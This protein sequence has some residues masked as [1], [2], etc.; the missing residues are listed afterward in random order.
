MLDTLLTLLIFQTMGEGLVYVFSLPIPGP[1]IGMLLLLCYLIIRKG[2]ADKLA[3]TT[4]QLLSHMALLFVPAGVGISV[5]MGRIADEWLP[6]M[7]SVVVST[8]LSIV[9][10]AL[11]I[12]WLSRGKQEVTK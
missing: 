8:L 6:I 10:T 4:N 3:P 11:V 1:V 9:A 12:R 7:V 2:V 5:H